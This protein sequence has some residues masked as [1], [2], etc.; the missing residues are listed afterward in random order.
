MVGR[1]GRGREGK[2]GRYGR[3]QRRI[4]LRN[5]I[6]GDGTRG[7][8][9]E[10]ERER[11]IRFDSLRATFSLSS[12]GKIIILLIFPSL[13]LPLSVFFLSVSLSLFY[14]LFSFLLFF[15]AWRRGCGASPCVRDG[16][17][18]VSVSHSTHEMNE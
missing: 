18:A 16:G 3:P 8:E 1:G 9:R 11:E 13:V 14:F 17:G 4:A 2:N 7:R 15:L 10:R 6:E 5:S 12:R